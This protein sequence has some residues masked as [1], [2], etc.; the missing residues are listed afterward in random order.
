MKVGSWDADSI[1]TLFSSLNTSKS[2]SNSGISSLASLVSDYNSIKSGAY[3]KLVKTY[4]ATQSDD[5]SSSKSTDKTTAS[6][7]TAE[8]STKTLKE[9]Q[10]ATDVLYESAEELRETAGKA[11]SMDELYDSVAT[12]VKDYNSVIKAATDSNT[13]TIQTSLADLTFATSTNSKL[14][15]N[16]GITVGED[17]TLSLDEDKFKAGTI[18]TAQALFKGVGS[19]AYNVQLNTSMMNSN[20]DYQASKA[21]TYGS[22]GSYSN[23]YTTGDLFDSLF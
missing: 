9:I 14:L 19:Y 16:I 13:D 2:S 8:D 15:S 6:T 11:E 23:N 22:D 5:K 10:T 4:Y 12:F 17:N 7:S 21:N 18:D 3:G 1:G 20:A